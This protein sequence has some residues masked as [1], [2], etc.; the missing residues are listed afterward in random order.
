[1]RFQRKM[2]QNDILTF[3]KKNQG[4]KF[5]AKQLSDEFDICISS[6]RNNCNKLSKQMINKQRVPLKK[7]GGFQY[8]YW[9]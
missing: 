6:I 9:V 7:G 1:M 5:S 8:L 3:L 2:S 4:K